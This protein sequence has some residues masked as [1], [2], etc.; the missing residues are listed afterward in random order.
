MRRSTRSLQTSKTLLSAFYG[1][2][3]GVSGCHLTALYAADICRLR[4]CG[5]S[6]R[7]CGSSFVLYILSK[8]QPHAQ[9]PY[10]AENELE[11]LRRGEILFAQL[12]LLSPEQF[13]GTDELFD[14]NLIY[15]GY[16]DAAGGSFYL[17]LPMAIPAAA[18][19]KAGAWAFMKLLF[20]SDYYATRGGWLPLQSGFEASIKDALADGASEESLQ[21]LRKYRKT[22][23]ARHITR[24]QLPIFWRTK[25][26]TSSQA[27]GRLRKRRNESISAC[28]CI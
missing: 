27:Q 18:Q 3:G 11:A 8:V 21:S 13:A 6:F 1:E 2:T 26:A 22:S 20:S 23:A 24:K 9:I 5:S 4:E 15:P 25:R 10:T 12:M 14:G 16:P 17:N 19:E 28:S 7:F